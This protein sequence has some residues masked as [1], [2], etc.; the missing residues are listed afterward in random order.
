MVWLATDAPREEEE[1]EV[2]EEEEGPE[3]GDCELVPRAIE[4]S[5]TVALWRSA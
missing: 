5:A 3:V 4:D 1:E 2:A